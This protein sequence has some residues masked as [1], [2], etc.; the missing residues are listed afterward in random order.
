MPS[1]GATEQG[2][3][4]Q[5]TAVFVDLVNF[6]S[7]A[8][9]ADP[10]D[11]QS[12]LESFYQSCREIL[13]SYDG[14]VTEYLGDGVVAFFG[15]EKADELAAGKS[16]HATLEVI[17]K[18]AP[19]FAD[20]RKLK[21]RAGI[22]TGEVA[23]PGKISQNMPLATG[24]VTTLARRIQERAEPET[25]L[26][27]EHTKNLLRGAVMLEPVPDQKLKGF[28]EPRVL[29]RATGQ[30]KL[31]APDAPP[32]LVGRSVERE[33]IKNAEKPCLVIGQAGY[34]KSA[35]AHAC[36]QDAGGAIIIQADGVNRRADYQPFRDWLL[37]LCQT[38]TPD[39][40]DLIRVFP[41]LS[42]DDLRALALVLGLA[43]GQ[44]LF[45]GLPNLALK[46]K[47]EAALW[48][49]VRAQGGAMVLFEDLHWFDAASLA[50]LQT[51]IR[52]PANANHRILMTSRED[53]KVSK[54]LGALDLRLVNLPA[55]NAAESGEMLDAL[56]AAGLPQRD[57]ELL[58]QRAGG[59]P[60]F[61]QQLL[62]QRGDG[63]GDANVPA[64][65]MDL[66][67]E[68]IDRTG[69]AKHII[70]QAAALGLV[71]SKALLQAINPDESNL[72]A[73]LEKA[74][75]V[76]VL[77]K[78]AGDE[79]AFSHG[80]LRQ[81][82]YQTLLRKTRATLHARIAAVQHIRFLELA[83]HEPSAF[84]MLKVTAARAGT[85]R[86]PAREVAAYQALASLPVAAG[87]PEVRQLEMSKAAL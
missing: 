19:L 20:G 6:S 17:A 44:R 61:L 59:V 3:R 53:A 49:A 57:K 30:K 60:L 23:T 75:G 35:L 42:N 43:E 67:A 34:G 58:I 55:L 41:A 50:V 46:P 32:V 12:W 15:L 51:I 82:A 5:V 80:L 74:A 18:G 86:M 2:E 36:I 69:T 52:D 33:I 81:A 37:G 13:E 79:W 7:V 54:F 29:Y 1:G 16:V 65:L 70:Q 25:V 4:K 83:A 9:T 72:D 26:I 68:R 84:T 78:R 21:I 47:I 10:E 73:M 45:S 24:M 77:Q 63:D 11:L 56:S 38:N 28:T 22:A 39:F 64:T 71:F 85:G 87:I 62:S 27:S 40:N 48:S 8:S 76:G 14:K 66:L 31:Q